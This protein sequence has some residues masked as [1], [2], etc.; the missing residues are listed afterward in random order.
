MCNG[1]FMRSAEITLR[2]SSA[3]VGS[4][5]KRRSAGH[6]VLRREDIQPSISRMTMV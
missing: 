2:H 3:V 1:R 5:I 6:L 4:A